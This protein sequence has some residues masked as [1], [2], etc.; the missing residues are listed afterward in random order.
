MDP[1]DRPHMISDPSLEIVR[2]SIF[3]SKFNDFPSENASFSNMTNVVSIAMEMRLLE[4]VAHNL[5]SN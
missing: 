5:G 3:A 1:F 4:N 2:Q